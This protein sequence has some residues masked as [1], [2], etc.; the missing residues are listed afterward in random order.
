MFKY[1]NKKK[2]IVTKSKN[3]WMNETEFKQRVNINVWMKQSLKK[4]YNRTKEKSRP[5]HNFENSIIKEYKSTSSWLFFFYYLNR[6]VG[7]L[8]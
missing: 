1:F 6:N 2:C 8:F 5:E 4:K 3:K 7:Y